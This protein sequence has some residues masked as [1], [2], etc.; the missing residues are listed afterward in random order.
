MARHN[1]SELY[2][3]FSGRADTLLR[4]YLVQ[5]P[6]PSLWLG[7]TSTDSIV[8]YG[9]GFLV[10]RLFHL[11]GEFCRILVIESALGGRR[12]LSGTILGRSPSVSRVSDIPAIIKRPSVLR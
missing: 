12:T 6:V 10:N 2:G 3:R 8:D 5:S 4:D 7:N 9:R 11:W 1:L